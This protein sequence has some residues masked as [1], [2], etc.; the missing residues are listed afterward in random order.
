M[1]CRQLYFFETVKKLLYLIS[2]FQLKCCGVNDYRD[3][4]G[5]SGWPG[6]RWVPESCCRWSNHGCGR[7]Y[8]PQQWY[9]RVRTHSVL[10]MSIPTPNWPYLRT[11]RLVRPPAP[12][13]TPLRPVRPLASHRTPTGLAPY[14][15]SSRTPF[16]YVFSAASGRFYEFDSFIFLNLQGY[17]I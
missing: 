4:F 16:E 10:V 11:S 8:K 1:A 17:Q 12:P 2:N 15:L 6:K 13:R 9:A 7:E 14:A 3:W 5:S